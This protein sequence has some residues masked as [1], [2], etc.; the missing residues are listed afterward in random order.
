MAHQDMLMM[1]LTYL[2]DEGYTLSKTVL[3]D[4][5]NIKVAA[6]RERSNDFKAFRRAVRGTLLEIF[7]SPLAR[8]AETPVLVREGRTQTATLRRPKSWCPSWA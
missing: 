7:S 3:Q 2:Q 5:A 6:G 4:E 1:I 8:H